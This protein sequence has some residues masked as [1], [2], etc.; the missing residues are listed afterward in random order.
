MKLLTVTDRDKTGPGVRTT[1]R[2]FYLFWKHKSH[3]FV[4]ECIG[5]KLQIVKYLK[6]QF[7]YTII[8]VNLIFE[9]IMSIVYY[10]S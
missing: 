4:P 7:I 2:T 6:I 1:L 3:V 8:A 9:S 10:F 5:S